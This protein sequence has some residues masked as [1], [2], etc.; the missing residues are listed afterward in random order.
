MLK[1]N[2]RRIELDL[3]RTFAIMCVLLCHATEA[4]FSF[5][6]FIW[7]YLSNLSK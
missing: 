6:K 1:E 4:F 7:E 2:K 5:D 3:A